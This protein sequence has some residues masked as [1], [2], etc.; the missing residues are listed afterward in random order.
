LALRL[1]RSRLE[2]DAGLVIEAEAELRRA[3][4]DLRD[5]A[6]GLF[7]VVLRDEGLAAALGALAETT[8]L[9]VLAAPA[10]RFQHTAET[11]AYLVAALA[12]DAGPATVTARTTGDT[13]VM[14]VD[15]QGELDSLGD[16]DDRV[17]A[18]G[19]HLFRSRTQRDGTHLRL[20]ISTTPAS[21][22]EWRPAEPTR[23][24]QSTPQQHVGRL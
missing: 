7:P 3:I 22:R 20:V 21:N 5:L 13:L 12:A 16:L 17:G 18:I 1:L 9:R 8:R 10:G 24:A 14:D 19:G 4:R 11:T 23:D 2:P 6:R 15:V